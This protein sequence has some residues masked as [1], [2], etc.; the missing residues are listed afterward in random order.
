M[1]EKEK[2]VEEEE[3]REGR[4]WT[5]L[6]LLLLHIRAV[7]DPSSRTRLVSGRLSGGGLKSL[8]AQGQRSRVFGVVVGL[9]GKPRNQEKSGSS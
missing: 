2:E 5:L 7:V 4:M 6:L 1:E 9:L 8:I 3:S